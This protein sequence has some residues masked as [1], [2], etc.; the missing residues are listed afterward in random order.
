[1]KPFIIHSYYLEVTLCP[2]NTWCYT[3]RN[4]HR[5]LVM[6]HKMSDI[7]KYLHDEFFSE[8]NHKVAFNQL[9]VDHA[10]ELELPF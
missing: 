8:R 5:T 6:S 2:D 9:P 3:L 10:P 4:S 1:M 7:T